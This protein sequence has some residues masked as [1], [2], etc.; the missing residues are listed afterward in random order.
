MKRKRRAAPPGEFHDPLSNYEEPQFDDNL[1]R[2]LLQDVISEVMTY[3]PY[4][5]IADHATVE[6]AMQM[7]AELEIACVMVTHDDKLVGVFSERDVINKVSENFR[8]VKDKPISEFMTP[9]PIV[10][11]ESDCPA[12]AINQMAIGGFRHIPVLTV[13]ERIAGMLGPQRVVKYVEK[14]L[15]ES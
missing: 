6:Q 1:E 12:K 8:A 10:V 14:F 3:Q 2:S 15:H 13:D 4:K 9:D 7:M 11:H 5:T